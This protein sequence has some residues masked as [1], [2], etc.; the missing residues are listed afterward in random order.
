LFPRPLHDRIRQRRTGAHL[1]KGW[2]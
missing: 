1:N 2:S